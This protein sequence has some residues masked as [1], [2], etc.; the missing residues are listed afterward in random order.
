MVEHKLWGKYSRMC[1]A[2]RVGQTANWHTVVLLLRLLGLFGRR[3]LL[4][5]A[6]L[7]LL[8]GLLVALWQPEYAEKNNCRIC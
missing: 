1:A 3:L 8:F 4:I 5:L 2:N 7:G 6:F